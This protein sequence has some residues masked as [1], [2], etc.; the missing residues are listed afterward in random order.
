MGGLTYGAIEA[1]ASGFTAPEVLVALTV[2][3]VALICFLTAQARGTHPMVLLALL[4][5]RAV[6][7]S[8]VIGFAFMVA[9]YGLPF[10]FSLY[11]QQQRGLSALATGALFLPMMLIGAALTPVSARLV[12]RVGHRPPIVTGLLVMAVGSVVLAQLPASA[13]LGVLSALLV[14]IGLGGPLVMPPTTAVLLNNVH[15]HRA[16]TASG[17][18]NTSRQIGGALAVAVFGGRLADQASFMGGLRVS[19]LIAA[20]VVVLAAVAAVRLRTTTHAQEVR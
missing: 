16:G 6:A 4:R 13:P 1:G 20:V 11:F 2:A 19:L 5:T 15:G 7:V 18:F 17:V 3:V 14:L 9:Y 12:E 10:V 8:A